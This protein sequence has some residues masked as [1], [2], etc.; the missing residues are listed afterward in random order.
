MRAHFFDIDTILQLDNKVWLID[1]Q[2]PNIPL[3]KISKSDFE[4]I[5][6]GIYKKQSN[7]IKFSGVEYWVPTKMLELIKIKCKK[8]NVDFSNLAFSLQEF[9]NQ[10]IIDMLDYKIN[11]DN[12]LHL[13]N[14][15][16]DIYIIC[17]KNSKRNY[18]MIISKIED[19]LKE[20]GLQIKKYY[21]ISETYFNRNQDDICYKKVR[22]ILQHLVGFRTDGDKLTE[23]E[24][25]QYDEIF[26]YDD[27]ELSIS[28]SIDINKL[29][30]FLLS[31][32][33]STVKNRIKQLLKEKEIVLYTNK[34]TS[35][36]VNKF[37][38]TKVMIE[39]SN[40]IKFFER[41][42]Y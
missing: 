23:E 15:N 38:T 19:K 9:M 8:H 31:N 27:E 37:I 2:S 28:Q 22:L 33:D 36:K 13:K 26:F 17:S 42:K 12:I 6:S 39:Y 41:F 35:N 11:Y 25:K 32:T 16:D 21:F 40:L 24:V 14:T 30:M 34:V 29:L 3:L 20:N 1:K 10:E 4:L 5:K 7:M 18:E